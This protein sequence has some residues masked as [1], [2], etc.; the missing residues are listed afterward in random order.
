MRNVNLCKGE[1]EAKNTNKAYAPDVACAGAG[2]DSGNRSAQVSLDNKLII[3]ATR[4]LRT[5]HTEG[6]LYAHS[7]ASSCN[8][9]IYQQLV[10]AQITSASAKQG[11][12]ITKRDW[13]FLEGDKLWSQ[14]VFSPIITVHRVVNTGFPVLQ[15]NG[16]FDR[17]FYSKNNTPEQK[18][19][20]LS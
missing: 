19:I 6:T 17:G 20:I 18:L 4:T 8:I 15:V 3:Q 16:E 11:N 1:E 14:K 9:Y 2:A 10:I 12:P 5:R 7:Y 13:I